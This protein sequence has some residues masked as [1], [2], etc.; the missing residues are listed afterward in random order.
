[1]LTVT[2]KAPVTTTSL[3]GAGV[4]VAVLDSGIVPHGNAARIKTTRDFTD[5]SLNPPAA[6][7]HV[8]GYGHGTHVAGLI[9]DE[10]ADAEGVAPG[11]SY[12]D[13]RVLKNDGSGSTS[14]VI[15]ALG[16]AV[17]N[18]ATYGIDVINLSLGHPI[19]EV[20]ATDPLVQAVEA[21][22]RTGIIVVVSSGNIGKN[23]MT[24]VVGY[25]G[26]T[27]P[28]N[29]PSAITVGATK[30]HD[31]VTPTDDE[32]ADYSS[33]GPTWYDGYLKPDIAA[34]GHRLLSAAD[35][36]QYLYAN[37]AGNRGE[38]RGG[39]AYLRLSGTSMAAGVVSGAVALVLE[40]AKQTFGQKPTPNAV[41]AM[42]QFSAFPLSKSNG[43]AYDVLTQGVGSLNVPGAIAMARAL[44][45]AVPV[46]TSW[47]AGA[48]PLT[49]VID[50]QTIAWGQNIVWGDNLIWGDAI[51]TRL[52]AWSD[53]IVWG[54][55][56]NDNIVWGEDDN[57]VWGDML[58]D[59][60]IVWGDNASDDNIVWGDSADDNI[61]WGDNVL[62]LD[63]IVWGDTLL[64]G[65]SEENIVW[66]ETENVVWGE[67][68]N[69]VWGE[70]SAAE[71]DAGAITT[72]DVIDVPTVNDT[73]TDSDAVD[74]LNVPA[75]WL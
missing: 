19:Y 7:V 12:V 1:L 8:D 69:V 64:W 70:N 73:S 37:L 56:D 20:A 11:V 43:D 5:G 10:R 71:G 42:L 26:V 6:T 15:N 57:I 29:A 32:I 16:W 30:T 48:I 41:K 3:T 24:G 33:R 27:S 47:V 44:N 35:P 74:P 14:H 2:Y 36:S 49:T 23:K 38:S 72:T 62:W 28:G 46:G 59:D 60:N 17:A 58:R 66:G 45:P 63:N 25:A 31:T 34:P 51:Y 65:S 9:G 54:D 13:L 40:G 4:T 67:S 53:N 75:E 50:G 61:V 55:S 68:D 18:R 39:Q 52:R 22:V 21:A